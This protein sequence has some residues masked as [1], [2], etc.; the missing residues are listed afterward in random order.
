M[1]SDYLYFRKPQGYKNISASQSKPVKQ[2]DYL[3]LF[4]KLATCQI[5]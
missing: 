4:S 3:F 5:L 1:T 2:I